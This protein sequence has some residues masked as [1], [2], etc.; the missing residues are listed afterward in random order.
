MLDAA[1]AR[2]VLERLDHPVAACTPA[3]L[4]SA[5]GLLTALRPVERSWR[6]AGETVH[7]FDPGKP[8]R[9]PNLV[10]SCV[11]AWHCVHVAAVLLQFA[12]EDPEL[13]AVLA[14]PLWEA[15]LG[16]VL[17]PATPPEERVEARLSV[18]VASSPGPFTVQVSWRRRARAGGW[19]QPAAV[20]R[21]PASLGVKARLS[22]GERHALELAADLG[23]VRQLARKRSSGHRS[24]A[25]ADRLALRLVVALEGIDDVRY[26]DVPIR[27]VAEPL[28]PRLRGTP[29]GDVLVLA[30]DPAVRRVWPEGIALTADG[31]LAPLDPS[32]RPEVRERLTTA[33]PSVPEAEIERFVDRATSSGLAVELPRELTGVR[34]A[35]RREAR[36]VLSE[37]GATLHVR[38]AL[39]YVRAGAAAV[40]EPGQEGSTVLVP[41]GG[42][43]ARDEDWEWTVRRRFEAAFGAPDR[44]EY[45]GDAAV[46]FLLDLLPTLVDDWVVFGEDGL[47]RYRVSGALTPSVGFRS[48]E[49]WF[50]LDVRFT[51]GSRSA[52]VGQVLAS[53]LEGRRAVRLTDGT[54]AALPRRWLDRHGSAVEDLRTVKR[55]EGRLGPWAAWMASEL[56]AETGVVGAQVWLDLAGQVAAKPAPR[57][58][59]EGL[60][61]TL[62]PYQARGYAWLCHLR[63]AGLHGVL[64]DD[65]GLGKTVQALAAL[66]DTHRTEGDPSLV[67][68][69]TSVL[70]G[71][72]DACQRFAPGLRVH[73]HHGSSRGAI[74]SVDVVLTT[75][76]VLRHDAATLTE[77]PWRWLV[78][79]EAQAVKNPGS[80]VSRTA[81]TLIARHRLALTG[82]PVENHLTELWSLFTILLPGLLG[83]RRAFHA[84]YAGPASQDPGAAALGDLRERIRPFVLRRTK[85]VVAPELPARTDIT[86]VCDL[87]E[88][89]RRLYD[90]VR[91][92]YRHSVTERRKRDGAGVL[93]LH[94][95][96]ALGRL[97]EAA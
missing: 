90:Q 46:A 77:R 16:P 43:V 31:C 75:W 84:R 61:A 47:V 67:V 20:P 95:L 40:V 39:A 83:S 9:S 37:D 11:Q 69:P 65:M 27:A 12:S 66:V 8:V 22:P 53:W 10:C 80:R 4:A 76:G 93:R 51:R 23:Q 56:L 86:L 52:P 72:I 30:W 45:A 85:A 50:D 42:R 7:R 91:A 13:A 70:P 5:I 36:L 18:R 15:V 97:R 94:V 81:R 34:A 89:E 55:A 14:Q 54:L 82:T 35:D 64:A 3:R 44:T 17:G 29:D 96:E 33:L 73:V 74:G 25:I 60:E 62:R 59:P 41:D 24:G 1:R 78:L 71:W 58:A 57:P 32:I 21:D 92:T 2:L 68:A 87:S 48:G 88:G 63:D 19:T 79:D 49:D 6:V 26:G 28:R 38:L